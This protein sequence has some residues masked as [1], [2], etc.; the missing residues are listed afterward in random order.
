MKPTNRY[1]I[2]VSQVA[3]FFLLIFSEPQKGHKELLSSS[4]F[5]KTVITRGVSFTLLRIAIALSAS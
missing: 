4:F 1:G 2:K 3:F 5:E